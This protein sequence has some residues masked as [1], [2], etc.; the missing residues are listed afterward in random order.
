MEKDHE[1]RYDFVCLFVL[2]CQDVQIVDAKGPF[3]P[4][5]TTLQH[6]EVKGHDIGL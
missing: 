4:N 3:I 6:L 5:F 1:G 2:Q